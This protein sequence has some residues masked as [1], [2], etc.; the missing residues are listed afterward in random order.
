VLLRLALRDMTNGGLRRIFG[1]FTADR[2]RL[3]AFEPWDELDDDDPDELVRVRRESMRARDGLFV[4]AV[5]WSDGRVSIDGQDVRPP[6]G[7][8]G[9]GDYE[10]SYVVPAKQVSRLTAAL[11]GGPDDDPLALLSGKADLLLDYGKEALQS[12]GLPRFGPS[13]WLEDNG[14]DYELVVR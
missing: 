5:E 13:A 7:F 12:L 14:I 8:G 1:R 9:G 3:P 10:Y 2:H 6:S 11:G 4:D